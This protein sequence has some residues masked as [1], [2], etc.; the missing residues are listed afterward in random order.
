M[1]VKAVEKFIKTEIVARLKLWRWL[2]DLK[3][4]E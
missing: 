4:A 2:G 3:A 1:K